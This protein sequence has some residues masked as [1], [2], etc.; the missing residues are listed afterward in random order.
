MRWE[1]RSFGMVHGSCRKRFW[2]G[3][4]PFGG[5][6]RRKR[7]RSMCSS[8][9]NWFSRHDAPHV[10]SDG[11]THLVDK[12]LK[13]HIFWIKCATFFLLEITNCALRRK[14]RTLSKIYV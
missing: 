11:T 4:S 8:I 13:S 14:L 10:L 9:G 6:M 5:E 3:S 2:I 12:L 7:S 1:S